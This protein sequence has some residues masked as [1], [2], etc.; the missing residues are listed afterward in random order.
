MTVIPRWKRG[1]PA[2]SP[3]LVASALLIVTSTCGGA[4]VAGTDSRAE[5][6][7][8]RVNGQRYSVWVANAD[9]SAARKIV[10]RAYGGALSADGRWLAF[11]RLQDSPNSARV[12]LYVVGL[13]GG[14]PRRIGEVRSGEWSPRR[15]EL[16]IIDAAGLVVVDPASGTRRPLV[17]GRD[18]S[19]ISFSPAGP[20]WIVYQRLRWTG[21]TAPLGRLWLMRPD[22]S[23]KRLFARGAE[24]LRRGFPVFGL[25]P[26]ALS[27]DGRHLLACQTFEFGCPRVTLT[28]PG[29]KRDGFPKLRPLER[30][31]GARAL[32]LSPDGTRVLVDVGSPHDDRHHAVYEVPFAGGRMRLIA[33]DAIAARWRH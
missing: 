4:G 12:R 27:E 23:G 3:A 2:R 24:G 1:R 6:T 15:A 33:A 11:S 32:D 28:V 16:A 14:K 26:L 29:G 17:R 13:A 25:D 21:G 7:F 18:L 31:Q 30:E 5:L 20:A 22:G 10:S 9:G 8:T 19:H